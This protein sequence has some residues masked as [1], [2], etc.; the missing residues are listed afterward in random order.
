MPIGKVRGGHCAGVASH[1]VSED[2]G[3][4]VPASLTRAMSAAVAEVVL[5][6]DEPVSAVTLTA[7]RHRVADC[8]ARSGLTD[9]SGE[10]FVLAVYELM[11]NAVR[12]GGGRAELR[13]TR[14]QES[15][16]CAVVD[17]GGSGRLPVV[18]SPNSAVAGGRGLWLA[19][20]L[21]DGLMLTQREDGV[22]ATVT[23][24][25]PAEA[26]SERALLVPDTAEVTFEVRLNPGDSDD[27]PR[28]LA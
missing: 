25:L 5:L 9:Q 7:V 20:Q 21:S 17:Y 8:V 19:Q 1:V 22:T 18:K 11:T 13:L 10:D 24:C 4:E 26:L 2:G 28:S 12:H 3:V 14:L 16:T 27:I 15:L 6:A 23:A